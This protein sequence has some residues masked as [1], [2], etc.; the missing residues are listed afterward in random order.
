MIPSVMTQSIIVS[1]IVPIYNAEAYLTQCIDSLLA[2]TLKEIEIILVNDGSTD[3]SGEICDR[4]AQQ[5]YRIRVVH[6]SNEGVSL[7]REAG[8]ELAKGEFII[9]ADSDDWAESTMAEDLYQIALAEKADMVICDF[10]KDY[11]STSSYQ[12]QHPS[13]LDHE[14]ILKELFLDLHGSCCNKLISAGS[15]KKLNIHFP[16]TFTCGEDL[17]VNA[18]LCCHDIKVV[19]LPKA[20]YHYRT[21]LNPDSITKKVDVADALHAWESFKTMMPTNYFN[22]YASERLAYSIAIAALLDRN[23]GD[24]KA[25]SIIREYFKP[26]CRYKDVRWYKIIAF[27]LGAMYL[28]VLIIAGL[29]IAG[30]R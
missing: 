13:A 28:R 3:R 21:D 12:R 30:E 7:A 6:K 4:Y 26:A 15:Y 23:I 2:Q 5:D 18:A 11:G 17:Y 22:R 16:T 24:R 25:A 19:Y 27:I 10:Y 20:Y 29:S 8:T 1:I 9:H 14:T